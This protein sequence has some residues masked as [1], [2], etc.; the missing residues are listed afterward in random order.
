MV[1]NKPLWAA[2]LIFLLLVTLLSACG[3]AATTAGDPAPAKQ[4]GKEPS[5]EKPAATRSFATV[6]AISRSRYNLSGSSRIITAAN[7]C[8]SALTWS[9]SNRRPSTIRF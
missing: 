5:K 7:C 6:K 1:K 3:G 2:G 4:T 9:A 8:P